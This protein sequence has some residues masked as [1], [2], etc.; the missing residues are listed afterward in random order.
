MR[1]KSLSGPFYK[2]FERKNEFVAFFFV[3]DVLF[4]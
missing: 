3:N 2:Y 1:I 4:I